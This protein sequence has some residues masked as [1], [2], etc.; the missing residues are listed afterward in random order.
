VTLRIVAAGVAAAAL[1]LPG[2]ARASAGD[3]DSG[4]GA[5][6]L[7]ATPFGLGARAS[8]VALA[9]DGRLLVAGASAVR[10]ASAS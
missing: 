5:G 8:A 3:V 2:A 10:E 1:A 7:A 4:F 6:G 9:P